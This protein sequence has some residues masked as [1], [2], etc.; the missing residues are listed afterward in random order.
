MRTLVRHL[1]ILALVATPL[2]PLQAQAKPPLRE[3][4]AIDDA[5]FDLGIADRIRKNCPTISARMLKAIGEEELV[6]VECECHEGCQ[7][8]HD[9]KEG[10][11]GR[12]GLERHREA[13]FQSEARL[14][15]FTAMLTGTQN[16]LKWNAVLIYEM[17][18]TRDKLTLAR[19]HH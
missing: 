5:L 1:T 11:D 10:E 12:G 4:A 7:R 14:N 9:T 15:G 8:G 13:T 6:E 3:V 18:R 19:L 16:L 17:E 2:L